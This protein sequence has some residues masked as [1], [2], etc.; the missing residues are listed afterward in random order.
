MPKALERKLA[1]EASKKGLS[2]EHADAYVYGAMRARGWKPKREVHIPGGSNHEV[3]V[4]DCTEK[5]N[6]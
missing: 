3:V 1:R 6:G 5:S 2:G 4:M